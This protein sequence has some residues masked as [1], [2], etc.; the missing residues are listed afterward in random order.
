MTTARSSSAPMVALGAASVSPMVHAPASLASTGRTARSSHALRIARAM[1]NAQAPTRPSCASTSRAWA[2][3]ATPRP[4]RHTCG[5][6]Q[7]ASPRSTRLCLQAASATTAGQ[8]MS[9]SCPHAQTVAPAMA[10]ACPTADARATRGGR[11][12]IAPCMRA[13][14]TSRA[15]NAAATRAANAWPAAGANASTAGSDPR[16][17]GRHARAPRRAAA[18][19]TAA[20]I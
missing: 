3:T 17:R 8:A 11:G 5:P 15:T 19:A 14:R 4:L 2:S 7:S 13:L 6:C 18:T 10:L 12:T 20:S 1:A 9:A 16:A